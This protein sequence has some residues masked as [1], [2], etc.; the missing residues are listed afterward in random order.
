MKNATLPGVFAT[1]VPHSLYYI[2]SV[3][4]LRVADPFNPCPPP[5]N[6]CNNVRASPAYTNSQFQFRSFQ[7][8]I[9]PFCALL[10]TPQHAFH[11]HCISRWLKTRNV[12]PLDNREWEMQKCVI[13]S[14]FRPC[15][16]SFS[17][18]I[19]L[20]FTLLTFASRPP[21]TDTRPVA[22]HAACFLVFCSCTCRPQIPDIFCCAIRVTRNNIASAI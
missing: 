13:V 6:Y 2:F 19:L 3:T 17:Q 7:S 4:N 15:P 9:R 22:S 20:P 10:G 18:I 11:F 5:W 16:V 21:D 12:C 1:C 14:Q 8:P